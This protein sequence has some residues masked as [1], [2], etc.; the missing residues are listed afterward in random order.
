LLKTHLVD[1]LTLVAGV[2]AALGLLFLLRKQWSPSRRK[3]TNEISGFYIST[4]GT[5]YAVIIAFMLSGVWLE[6]EEAQVN[7]EKEAN[8]LVSFFRLARGLPDTQR[9]QLQGLAQTY[10]KV[11]VDEEWEAMARREVSS[12]GIEITDAMWQDVTAI[13]VQTAGEQAILDH[14]ISELT[15]MSE[16]RR[17]RMLQ[18]RKMLPSILWAVLI[19][20]GVITVGISCLFGVDN[21]RLHVIQ[22]VALTV[23]VSLLLIAI[24]DLDSPFQG[25]VHVPPDGFRLALETMNNM[26]GG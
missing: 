11:M 19:V 6:F 14:V 20:G 24:A 18:S 10:A 5:I 3:E 26:K 17:I 9:N 21:V 13:Q 25:V 4:I 16:H 2:L 22:T 8:C 15:S 7:T 12:R 23:V 1:G